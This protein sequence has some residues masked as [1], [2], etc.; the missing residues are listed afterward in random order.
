[1]Y[2]CPEVW[3]CCE[4]AHLYAERD[5]CQGKEMMVEL[6]ILLTAWATQFQYLN[7]SLILLLL[8][9]IWIWLLNLIGTEDQGADA[10][11]QQLAERGMPFYIFNA[12]V[13]Q[14]AAFL[15]C[16]VD[17][18]EMSL[19]TITS[20]FH[21]DRCKDNQLYEDMKTKLEAMGCIQRSKKVD[22]LSAQGFLL[23]QWNVFLPRSASFICMGF[24]L[25]PLEQIK[26]WHEGMPKCLC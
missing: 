17:H 22:V 10:A 19:C 26:G 1:M 3:V 8:Q 23:R 12:W 2:K 18:R 25:N 20:T 13:T 11:R 4:W 14:K 16:T 21:L 15:G 7:M 24:L 9:S 5:R 6:I